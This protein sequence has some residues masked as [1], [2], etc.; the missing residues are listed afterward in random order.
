MLRHYFTKSI[1][2]LQ[3]YVHAKMDS[4]YENVPQRLLPQEY[5]GD[6]DSMDK[7]AGVSDI[8]H[9]FSL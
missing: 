1:S 2:F 7:L 5:G 8:Y 4:L 6:A 3:L 9:I